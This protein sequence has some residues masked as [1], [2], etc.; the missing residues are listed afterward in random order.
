MAVVTYIVIMGF[1][2]GYQSGGNNNENVF[3]PQILIATGS[4]AFLMLIVEVLLMKIGFYFIGS[5]ATPPFWLDIV[6]YTGYKLVF[7]TINLI[8]YLIFA[9]Q[10]LYY[11]ISIATGIIAA[12]F[13]IQTLRPYF[14]DLSQFASGPLM[15]NLSHNE[16]KKTR[17][18]FLGI[19]GGAQI[20]FIQLYGKIYFDIKL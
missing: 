14:R 20:L 10:F 6:C 13:M 7:V 18:I 15:D 8:I 3:S 1:V 12:V 4:S 16:P 11:V 5:V 19:V 2:V 9:S 17:K